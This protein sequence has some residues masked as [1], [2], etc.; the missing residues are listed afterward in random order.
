MLKNKKILVLTS[1]VTL[2]PVL[3]GLLLWDR[4][5]ESLPIHWNA[6]GEVDSYGSRAMVVFGL[7]GILL[8]LH[9]FAVVVPTLD[10]KNKDQSPQAR[11]LTQWI[12]PVLSLALAVFTYSTALGVALRVE[13]VLPVLMGLLFVIIG[14]LLPKC[15]RNYTIG[16]KVPWAL[17]SEE[18]W[19]ATHRLAGKVWVIGGILQMAMVFVPEM[20]LFLLAAM[21]L[22]MVLVPVVYSYLCYKKH[23]GE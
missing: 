6:A 7:F 19:N 23:S 3:A 20:S 5:P 8:V 21:I 10:P 2:L 11:A 18:N 17:E 22:L 12:V 1:I 4:L 16:I 14:N 13:I 9:W 15:R